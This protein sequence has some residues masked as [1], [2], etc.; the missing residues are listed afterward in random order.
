M[1][2]FIFVLA[3]LL[4]VSASADDLKRNSI[5]LRCLDPSGEIALGYEYALSGHH[6]LK[7]AVGL[8]GG[9]FGACAGYGYLT[10]PRGF[11]LESGIA[12]G[13]GENGLLLI[14]ESLFDED[15]AEGDFV[16]ISVPLGL[17]YSAGSGF[18]LDLGASANYFTG[19]DTDLDGITY[20]IPY[21][22]LGWGF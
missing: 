14:I 20:V 22:N 3:V 9:G 8:S 11:G 1:K 2:Y 13:F 7:A 15:N 19:T 18:R 4:I 5:T 10:N 12:A 17:R 16:V 21:L 6:R